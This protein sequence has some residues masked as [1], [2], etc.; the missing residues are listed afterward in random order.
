MS[1]V[2]FTKSALAAAALMASALVAHAAPI[3]WL[4]T[5]ANELATVDVATGTTT[6]VGNTGVFLTDIAFDPLGNLYGISF[7]SLY[8]VDKMNGSTTLIG[9]LGGVSGTANALVFGADGTLYMAGDSLYTVNTSTGASTAVGSIGFQSA[10]DLAFVGG[11]LFMAASN[12]HLIGV[13]IGTGLG[14]DIGDIG[15]AGVYGLASADNVTLYGMAGQNVFTIDTATAATGPLVTFNPALG[16]A[17]GSAFLTE[18]GAPVS[19]PGSLALVGAAL[20]AAGALRRRKA[21]AA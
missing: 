16:A 3:L 12:N 15:V 17:A 20:L 21:T 7:T 5:T 18:A 13:D 6:V 14:T 9:S 8:S 11:N 4:S 2:R 1:I 10:G 19:E